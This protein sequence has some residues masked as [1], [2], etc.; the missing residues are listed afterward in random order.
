MKSGKD[1]KKLDEMI[2]RAISEENIEFDAE[3]WKQK[4]GKEYSMLTCGATK[5]P[6]KRSW[7]I[8]GRNVMKNK[9]TKLAVAAVIII[10][11]LAG[12]NHFGGSIDGS[13]AAWAS[14]AERVMKIDTFTY[15]I[16]MTM[17]NVPNVPQGENMEMETLAYNSLEHGL[18]IDTY[19][20]DKIIST[21]YITPRTKAMLSVIHD[22]KKYIKIQMNDE[23]FREYQLKN[24][25][26]EMIKSFMIY[27]F[28]EL[29]ISDING[30]QAEG[31]M[32]T[33][34][35]VFAGVFSDVKVELWA[36][37]ESDLPVMMKINAAGENSILID[38]VMD[39]F[40][41][42][43]ELDLAELEPNI[44]ADYEL[45]A[46][47]EIP[48][49]DGKAAAEGLGIYADSLGKYPE[50][51]TIMAM[52]K[53]LAEDMR[54]NIDPNNPEPSNEDMERMM[55]VQAV[56]MF[57][58][59]LTQKG[60]EPAYY[61]KNVTV[62]DSDAVLMRWKISDN[63]YRVIFGDLSIEDVSFQELSELEASVK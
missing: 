47:V 40:Q 13:T 11:V 60:K 25:P 51:I 46:D 14:L 17:A 35:N 32:V 30:I 33:D 28:T 56:C 5:V 16:R 3:K 29:G 34:P 52:M 59:G 9:V 20:K 12:I 55:K 21:T 19:L 31:I 18:R 45:M 27:G 36:D 23:Q 63:K 39:D 24:N 57:Y 1:S 8:N 62:G 41:W 44:P 4:Y 37:V 42:N 58:M 54:K 22:R 26:R 15:R 6:L 53:E 61:G 48:G 49:D 10:A 2:A 7:L 38:M 43:V 50:K